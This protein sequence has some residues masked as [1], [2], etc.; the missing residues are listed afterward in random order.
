M[1]LE[2]DQTCVLDGVAY[3]RLNESLDPILPLTLSEKTT[4]S[5]V[6]GVRMCEDNIRWEHA[7]VDP[8]LGILFNGVDSLST[9]SAKSLPLGAKI[10]IG[11][12]VGLV[13]VGCIVIAFFLLYSPAFQHTVLPF[14][15]RRSK[16]GKG[17]NSAELNPTADST[18]GTSG[19]TSS[20]SNSKPGTLSNVK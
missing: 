13:I 15:K 18:R 20:W 6:S 10:G 4:K 2:A 9:P 17:H 7:W 12:G 1:F 19:G 5:Y 8:F 3:Y 11:V 16:Q 14:S